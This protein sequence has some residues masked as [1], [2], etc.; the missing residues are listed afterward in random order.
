[1]ARQC[2]QVLSA[3]G[4]EILELGAGTGSLAAALLTELA[5]LGVLPARYAILEV[6]ADLAARQRAR[7]AQLPAALRGR[8]VW[9][10]RLPERA[11]HG[12]ILANEI[13]DALPFR[14]V[15]WDDKSLKEIGVAR[16]ESGERRDG[17]D[18]AITFCARAA[19]ADAALTRAWEEILAGL[20]VPLP[21]DYT[22]EVCLRVAPWIGS[23]A[24][25]LASGVLLLCDYG[26]PRAQYYHPQRVSGTLRCHFRQRA[27]EDPHI[28]V[29]VQDIT[30][31]VDFTRIAEAAAG[32]GLA[33]SGFA[34]QAA[35]LLALGIEELVAAGSDELARARLAG[36]AQRLLLPGEM[37]ESFKALA[38]SRGFDAPLTGFA[39]QDLRHSL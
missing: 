36:E 39:L 12:V 23:L 21:P 6:S 8:M 4:G 30:A 19:P 15:H 27:H 7:L 28:N 33:V 3:T 5:A 11:L 9:L 16:G 1:V 32:A 37:G 2:A 10:Q 38:L 31:W 26:L 20:P 34:T 18:G 13:A 25:A 24:D 22:S 14:R 29:G 35:F 17:R